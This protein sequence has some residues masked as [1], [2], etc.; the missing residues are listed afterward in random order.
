MATKFKPTMV[1]FSNYTKTSQTLVT[2]LCL[3]IFMNI[4]N[5]SL[6][7]HLNIQEV[8]LYIFPTEPL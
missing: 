1:E 4:F 2:L 6:T 8:R 7:N 3:D 5:S